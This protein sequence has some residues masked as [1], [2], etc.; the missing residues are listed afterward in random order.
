MIHAHLN[1][2]PKPRESHKNININ[3][4]FFSSKFLIYL[5]ENYNYHFIII[6]MILS[7]LPVSPLDNKIQT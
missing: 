3:I 2:I 4:L 6:H 1:Y 5:Q 7:L